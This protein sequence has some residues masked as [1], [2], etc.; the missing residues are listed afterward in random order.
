[1]PIKLLKAD[2]GLHTKPKVELIVKK[3]KGKVIHV[4]GHGGP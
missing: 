1:M 4:T 3:V 2:I